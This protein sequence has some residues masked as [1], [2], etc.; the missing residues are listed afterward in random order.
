MT[1]ENITVLVFSK[2]YSLTQNKINY[3]LIEK[4]NDNNN[5]KKSMKIN[6]ELT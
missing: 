3:T 2:N 6:I 1:Q 4:I 5:N